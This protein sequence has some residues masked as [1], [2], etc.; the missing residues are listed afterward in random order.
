MSASL[1]GHN[2]FNHKLNSLKYA[3]KLK[4]LK[5]NRNSGFSNFSHSSVILAQNAIKNNTNR[6]TL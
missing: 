3:E 1:A 6:K 2:G 5:E 4:D